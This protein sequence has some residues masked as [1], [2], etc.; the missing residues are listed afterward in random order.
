[1]FSKYPQSGVPTRPSHQ[2]IIIYIYM[3]CY[4][5]LGFHNSW[6]NQEIETK[7]LQKK[8]REII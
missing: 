8:P 2:K 6:E 4:Y 1:M 5:A 3:D 7:F